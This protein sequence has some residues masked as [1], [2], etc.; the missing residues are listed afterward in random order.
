MKTFI[1]FLFYF[2]F[3]ICFSKT[4]DINL[5]EKRNGLYYEAYSSI[6][7]TGTTKG[8]AI[9]EIVRGKKEGKHIK[10]YNNGKILSKA[11]FKQ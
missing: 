6:P 5:L 10:Y 11:Y 9:G 8:N 3:Q 4:V 7:F 2:S 1:Y